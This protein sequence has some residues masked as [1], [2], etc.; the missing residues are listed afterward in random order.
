MTLSSAMEQTKILLNANY[1][2]YK[3]ISPVPVLVLSSL[4]ITTLT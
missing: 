1:I 2:C 4:L 3:Q